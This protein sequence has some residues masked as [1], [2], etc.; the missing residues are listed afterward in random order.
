VLI[1]VHAVDIFGTL[2]SNMTLFQLSQF[3]ITSCIGL[4]KLMMLKLVSKELVHFQSAG[5]RN[6][7]VDA[8]RSLPVFTPH[9]ST[10]F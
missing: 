10:R 2:N 6:D 7:P 9:V 4:P 3:G 5:T 8:I 1:H